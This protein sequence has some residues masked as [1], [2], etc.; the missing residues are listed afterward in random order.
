MRLRQG[1]LTECVRWCREVAPVALAD[2]DLE[3]I[4]HA[5]YLLHLSY[6]S[7][8][9][10]ER[11]DFRGIALPIYEEL[12]D[13]LGQANVLNNLG[14]DA[15]YEGRWDDALDHY[16]QSRRLRGRI[17]DV[18]GAAQIVGNIAEILSDQGR[19]S[20]ARELFEEAAAVFRDAHARFL[21]HVATGNLGRLAAR[22]GR[23]DDAERALDDA[24]NGFVELNAASFTLEARARLAELDILRGD[25][26]E[27][28]LERAETTLDAARESGGS[29]LEAGLL[30]MIGY[31]R[32]QAGNPDDARVAF[33]ESLSAAQK[34]EAEYEQALAHRALAD[35]GV[36]VERNAARAQTLLDRLGV[37]SLP[38][39]P[40]S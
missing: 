23:F 5:Y 29:P 20:E 32:A 6:T 9:W 24:L 21:E 38:A 8:G 15:Y 26:H 34:T 11:R 7:L 2:Q 4:A 17:G 28:A 3:S 27:R 18:V 37:V 13:L 35:A 22:E 19:T 10:A 30:R 16:E 12:G 1:K 36:D 33:E 31:A 40:L 25:R 14:I 39:V